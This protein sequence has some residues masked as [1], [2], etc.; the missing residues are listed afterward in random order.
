M[1]RE[2]P[3]SYYSFNNIMDYH[4]YITERNARLCKLYCPEILA[5]TQHLGNRQAPSRYS[6]EW[7]DEDSTDSSE[8]DDVSDHS[9]SD[10]DS[11]ESEQSPSELV[12]STKGKEVIPDVPA[13]LDRAGGHAGDTT[14]T[15]RGESGVGSSSSG[16]P[17]IG[18][19]TPA[20]GFITARALYESQPK[21]LGFSG[22]GRSWQLSA[23]AQP[24]Q[25]CGIR[26]EGWP[27]CVTCVGCLDLSGSEA[28][29]AVPSHR[30][31]SADGEGGQVNGGDKRGPS[32]VR[33]DAQAE[34]GG[35]LGLGAA[36]ATAGASPLGATF[37]GGAVTSGRKD[38]YLAQRKRKYAPGRGRAA[39]LP[40]RK[41]W[42]GQ[43]NVRY[44]SG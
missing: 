13:V 17:S 44:K 41:Y 12:I 21:R 15:I 37:S 4:F 36:Q 7:S 16:G 31:S 26:N 40:P 6:P 27:L 43:D 10:S 19:P 25:V 24:C 30:A 23:N 9:G 20:R 33:T 22:G 28:Q 18:G 8:P 1:Y 34:A 2:F 32:D 35:V 39:S 14:N 38:S 5:T 3:T 29:E 42:K 11:A